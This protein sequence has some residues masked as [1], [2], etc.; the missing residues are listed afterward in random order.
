[1]LPHERIEFSALTH[2]IVGRA[3]VRPDGT[4]VQ[5]LDA[6]DDRGLARARDLAARAHAEECAC[7]IMLGG[8][9]EG[10]NFRAASAPAL[11]ASFVRNLLAFLDATGM[12]GVDLDWEEQ[13]DFGNFLELVRELRAAR[14]SI[15]ITVP[16]FPV[17]INFGLEAQVAAFVRDAAPLVD[18][19]NV[20]SY[21]I[22]MAGP[23]GGWVTWH[24]GAL[25]GHAP[26][27]PTSVSSSLLAYEAA[28]VPRTKLGMGIGFCGIDYRPPNS[29]P[30]QDPVGGFGADDV[31]YRYSRLVRYI[32][33]H[34]EPR[35]DDAAK[36]PWLSFPGG[37]S[38]GQGFSVAGFISYENERSIA[39]KGAWLHREGFG[40]CILWTINYD[41]LPA[42][43]P[44]PLLSAVR[45]AFLAP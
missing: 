23:W 28:G 5:A 8:E 18:Q 4:I 30:Y 29:A 24:T 11:R 9:G 21:G 20:M 35:W 17:N 12:D 45:Q 41:V 3:S 26:N 15:I 6:F 1:M 16:V 43:G 33:A 27:R 19:I 36:Q 14:P 44:G 25:E 32:K 7:L 31:E 34:G 38:P 13:I 2:L 10:P 37:Y 39:E 42:S 40:G 22:G